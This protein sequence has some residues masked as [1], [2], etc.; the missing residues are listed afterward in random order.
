MRRQRSRGKEQPTSSKR[1]LGSSLTTDARGN[2][3]LRYRW[4]GKHRSVALNVADTPTARTTW[5]P[6]VEVVG[7]VVRE[8]R[9]PAPVLRQTIRRQEQEVVDDSPSLSA[10]ATRW[11][12]DRDP[13]IRPAQARDYRRHLR[14]YIVPRLGHLRIA[15]LKPSD[16]RGFQVE[17]LKVGPPV[18]PTPK[19]G[20]PSKQRPLKVKTVKNIVQSTLRAV[21]KG[22]R[23]DGLLSHAQ[24]AD[25]FDLDWPKTTVPEPDPFTQ[26]ELA[27]IETKFSTAIYR[28]RS[29]GRVP[30]PAYG[31]F[32]HLL[33]WTGMRPSE[34]AGLQWGDVDFKRGLLHVRRSRHLHHDGD[35][36]TRQ[37]RRTV[38]LAPATVAVLRA[39][40]PLRVKPDTYVFL[41]TERTPIEPN[42][43]LP[44]FHDVQ[45]A[46][47]IRVRGLYS[48]KD[49]FVSGALSAN[50]PAP[51]TWIE[52]QTGVAYATLRKHYARWWPSTDAGSPFDH[53]GPADCASKSAQKGTIEKQTRAIRMLRSA[54]GGT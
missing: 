39:L 10:F 31:T 52:E 45:R 8:G 42:N 7:R 28:T 26:S 29:V 51:V 35:P 47:G 44:H 15:A 2:L 4:Q 5:T 14:R 20:T 3:R 11:L 19:R 13:F 22:A 9:D 36:K 18:A 37:A 48:L 43:F 34:A 17:L 54:K 12:E 53:F 32:V 50:P 30:W 27:S 33:A 6:L 24:F 21:L 38:H 23:R 49:S 25:L 16:V 40:C 46:C 1:Y 41:N